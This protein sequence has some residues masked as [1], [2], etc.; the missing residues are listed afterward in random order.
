VEY[1]PE[2]ML[3]HTNDFLRCF[4]DSSPYP[5]ADVKGFNL[6]CDEYHRDPISI[7]P[8]LAQVGAREAPYPAT[9]N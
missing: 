8:E 1:S 4:D 9:D 2:I 3:D 5:R 7:A 6:R